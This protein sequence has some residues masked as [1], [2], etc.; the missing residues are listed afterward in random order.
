MDLIKDHVFQENYISF[1]SLHF[2]PKKNFYF[3]KKYLKSFQIIHL[4][5]QKL[6]DYKSLGN[7]C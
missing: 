3:T 5:Y 6:I 7:I 1:N 4:Y 2:S